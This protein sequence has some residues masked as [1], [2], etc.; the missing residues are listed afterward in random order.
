MMTPYLAQMQLKMLKQNSCEYED[1]TK[2][3]GNASYGNAIHLT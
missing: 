2:V 3:E 1:V